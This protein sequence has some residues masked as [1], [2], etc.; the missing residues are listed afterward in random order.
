LSNARRKRDFLLGPTLTQLT[1]HD[2]IAA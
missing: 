1:H 2:S